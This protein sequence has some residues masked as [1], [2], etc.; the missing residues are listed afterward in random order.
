MTKD[1]PVKCVFS[2][3][4]GKVIGYEDYYFE[5]ERVLCM[6]AFSTSAVATTIDDDASPPGSTE[7]DDDTG[8]NCK[9]PKALYKA[10]CP[11][12]LVYPPIPGPP[13]ELNRPSVISSYR[14]ST[15]RTRSWGPG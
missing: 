9:I 14:T 8:H 1:C 3:Q 5:N 11:H 13:T 6:R 10:F 12:V 2:G 15:C 7:H 4:I